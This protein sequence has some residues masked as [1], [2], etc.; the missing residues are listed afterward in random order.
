MHKEPHLEDPPDSAGRVE[1]KL[2]VVVIDDHMSVV[3]D[4]HL[5]ACVCVWGGG[6]T[7]NVVAAKTL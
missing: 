3:T 4:A 6:G 7:L 5:R 2:G 1:S